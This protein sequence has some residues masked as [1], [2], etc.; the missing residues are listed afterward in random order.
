MPLPVTF[1]PGS[2]HLRAPRFTPEP[3]TVEVLQVDTPCVRPVETVDRPG[4]RCMRLLISSRANGVGMESSGILQHAQVFVFKTQS[5]PVY[6]KQR[7]VAD[8]EGRHA[9]R[10]VKARH[11]RD[12]LDHLHEPFDI[13]A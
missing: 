3:E 9:C 2:K 10:V 6:G 12:D 7:R 1:A 8:R 11:R 4:G 13:P 5:T